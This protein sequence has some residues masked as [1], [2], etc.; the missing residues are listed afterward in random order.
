MNLH[1]VLPA[2]L[3]LAALAC[4]AA[5]CAAGES[6]WGSVKG[7]FIIQG[8]APKPVPLF[9]G[10]IPRNRN[11]LVVDPKT[12]GIRH[13]FI[14][15]RKAG[16]V[17]PALKKATLPELKQDVRGRRF[18]PHTML[19][20]TGQNV[21][22]INNDPLAHTPHGT[23]FKN[24]PFKQN[25]AAN[26]NKV[27]LLKSFEVGESF[28][29]PVTCDV[30]PHMKAHWL[31]LDHPYAAITNAKGEFEI[32]NLPTGIQNLRVWH[33]KAGLIERSWS[34]IV[35]DG[36]VTNLGTYE[37]EPQEFED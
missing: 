19:V 23:F 26:N 30:H 21:R 2:C 9:R 5:T 7:R 29:M 11:D 25:L 20:R 14:Y 24:R 8:D 4:P 32:K 6:G 12:K 31:I 1:N 36:E 17:H 16:D 13:I 28:P 35:R 37:V 22:I 18:V 33:E 3:L 34:V 10:G 27:G 15:L